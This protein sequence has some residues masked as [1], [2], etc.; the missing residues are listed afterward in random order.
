MLNRVQI[1]FTDE[2]LAWIRGRAESAGGR[3]VTSVVRE[4]VDAEMTRIAES[5]PPREAAE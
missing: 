1:L 4:L 5:Q 3:S 2:Q